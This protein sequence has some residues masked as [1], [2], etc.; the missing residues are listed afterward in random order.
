MY[1]YSDILHPSEVE[2]NKKF[3]S[4]MLLKII[5]ILSVDKIFENRKSHKAKWKPFLKIPCPMCQTFLKSIK[6][7]QSQ[8]GF[9]KD[10]Y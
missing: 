8:T 2:I 7:N 3:K 1:C 6:Y 4:F 5:Y 9:H 10:S